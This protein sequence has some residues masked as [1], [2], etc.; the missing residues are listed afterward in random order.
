MADTVFVAIA[1]AFFGLSVLY[2]LGCDRLI[3]RDSVPEVSVDGSQ[4]EVPLA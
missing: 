2:V 1:L 3:G 4:T